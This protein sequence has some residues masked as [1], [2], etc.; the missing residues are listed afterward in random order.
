MKVNWSALI[1]TVGG[2]VCLCGF[3]YSVWTG[4]EFRVI[5]WGVQW[6]LVSL[7][8]VSVPLVEGVSS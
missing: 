6:I 3:W 7:P 2:L 8:P 1:R 5:V 4:N